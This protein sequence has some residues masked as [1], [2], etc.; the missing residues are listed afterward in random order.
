MFFIRLTSVVKTSTWNDE[1]FI[2]KILCSTLLYHDDLSKKPFLLLFIVFLYSFQATL[3]PLCCGCLAVIMLWHL[4]KVTSTLLYITISCCRNILAT[5]QLQYSGAPDA[6]TFDM[7][8]KD[9]FMDMLV[10]RVLGWIHRQRRDVVTKLICSST[11]GSHHIIW[12]GSDLLH[13]RLA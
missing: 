12:G 11:I 13:K 4:H 7:T 1:T 5:S 10:D 3:H 8:Q 2:S 9:I 6:T